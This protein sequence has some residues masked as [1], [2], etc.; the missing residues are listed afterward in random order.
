MPRILIS[1][2]A[3]LDL[4]YWRVTIIAQNFK[5]D[6]RKQNATEK[7]TRKKNN[8]KTERPYLLERAPPSN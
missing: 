2:T 6:E 7:F 8:S 4:Y 1:I 3:L 5:M